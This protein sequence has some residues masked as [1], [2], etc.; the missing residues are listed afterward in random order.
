MASPRFSGVRV[1]VL[2]VVAI[3]LLAVIAFAFHR[4]SSGSVENA[5]ATPVSGQIGTIREIPIGVMV[6]LT[7]ALES[8]GPLYRAGAQLAE[9]D[10]NRFLTTIGSPYRV[11]LYF[12]DDRSTPDGALA[13]AQSLAARGIRIIFTYTSA[14][15]S[16]VKSFAEKNDMLVISY[17]S[18]S[19][20]LAIAGDNV[21][22]LL[23]PDTFQ[24]K[25]LASL[26]QRLGID[27][28]IVVYRGDDWGDGLFNALRRSFEGM[29]GTV[30]AGIRYDPEAKDFSAEASMLAS[31]VEREGDRERLAIMVFSFPG[32]FLA[33]FSA[34]ARYPSLL[35]V[36]W[37][38]SD[39]TVDDTKVRD[40]L[41]ER[42]VDSRILFICPRFF[43]AEYPHQEAFIERYRR[44][45]GEN[46]AGAI[47]ALYDGI[48]MVTFAVVLNGG[49]TSGSRLMK[50]LPEVAYRY[51]GYSGWTL[52]DESGDRAIASYAFRMLARTERG[53]EWITVG[54]Y[55]GT[56]GE[57]TLLYQLGG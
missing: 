30:I 26:L 44:I 49:D 31:Y 50:V 37:I 19:P 24:A 28:V 6:S 7:G 5:S 29:G 35:Q 1:L 39:G 38:G 48:W 52:L 36:K 13:A 51:F 57:I 15:T 21:F 11:K 16:A 4:L 9:E 45:T 53:I 14:A 18:T 2:A 43:T 55:E 8:Y 33:F 40:M 20:L 56:T 25:A 23:P 54:Y 41:G 32:D 10:I 22:R 46:P 47:Y 27:R 3:A 17:A 42:I 34:A 12:E